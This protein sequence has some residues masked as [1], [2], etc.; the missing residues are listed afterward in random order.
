MSGEYISLL[1]EL[2]Y[3]EVIGLYKHPCRGEERSLGIPAG[4]QQSPT[5]V[6]GHGYV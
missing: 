2:Q 3:L 4:W 5:A 6:R 1:K